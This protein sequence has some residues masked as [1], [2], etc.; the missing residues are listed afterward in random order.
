[1]GSRLRVVSGTAADYSFPAVPIRR[2]LL[3]DSLHGVIS[4]LRMCHHLVPQ[5]GATAAVLSHCLLGVCD[6][7]AALAP[8]PVP[9][10]Y[11]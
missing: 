9:A 2:G 7:L 1:M 11:Y 8:A 5:L 3:F 10:R 4:E 6:S